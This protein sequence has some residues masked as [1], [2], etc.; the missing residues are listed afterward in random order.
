VATFDAFPRLVSYYG[1]EATRQDDGTTTGQFTCVVIDC[2]VALG[3]F[4]RSTLNDDG[5]VKLEGTTSVFFVDGTVLEDIA[6]GV[7]VW[8]GGSKQ[9]RFL[10]SV[11]VLPDPG[12]YETALFGGIQIRR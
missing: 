10:F 9:G 11:P 12:D 3:S 2:C 5:S 4:D 8:E 1:V 6:L 7:T